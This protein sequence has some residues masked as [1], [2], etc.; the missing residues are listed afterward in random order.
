M[1]NF[2]A[3]QML[4]LVKD[5][6]KFEKRLKELAKQEASAKAAMD[7]SRLM[8]IEVSGQIDKKR[9]EIETLKTEYRAQIE[10]G[11]KPLDATKAEL[12]KREL[13]VNTEEKRL[14]KQLEKIKAD[15]DAIKTAT[16]AVKQR[17][18]DFEER[19]K[20]FET[21]AKRLAENA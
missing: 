17:E 12:S 4:D 16:A 8:N 7:K 5:S 2:S 1:S 10:L 20:A 3:D 19:V 21:A 6:S 18:V 15:Q 13:K 11:M 9:A 14:G